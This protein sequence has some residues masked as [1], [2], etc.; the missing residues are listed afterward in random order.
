MAV[1]MTGIDGAARIIPAL[2]DAL[3]FI[4]QFDMRTCTARWRVGARVPVKTPR[5]DVA[6]RSIPAMTDVLRCLRQARH[7]NS[8]ML[9]A[10]LRKLHHPASHYY[11]RLSMGNVLTLSSVAAV[12]GCTGSTCSCCIAV[13]LELVEQKLGVGVC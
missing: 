4:R 1:H 10:P 11:S 9:L 3:R 6:A 8:V 2:T 7:E 5:I 12:T 13:V